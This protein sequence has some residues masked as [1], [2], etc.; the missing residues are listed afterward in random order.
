MDSLYYIIHYIISYIFLYRKVLIL[1][2]LCRFIKMSN[3][4]LNN[5]VIT[6][7]IVIY[8]SGVLIALDNYGVPQSKILLC[9]VSH[10]TGYAHFIY[11]L[12]YLD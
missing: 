4:R 8:I 3:P 11:Y 5:L 2:F 6:G 1:D 7:S 10:V 12:D 9:R